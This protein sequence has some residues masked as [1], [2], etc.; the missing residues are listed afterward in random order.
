MRLSF[1]I[2]LA[3]L[4]LILSGVAVLFMG[5]EYRNAIFGPPPIAPGEKLFKVEQ[6]DKVSQITLS[7]NKGDKVDFKIKGNQWFATEPWQD[8]ADPT[9]LRF[10]VQFTA[11]LKVEEVLPRK[12]LNLSE[13]GLD[14]DYVRVTMLNQDGNTVC[15]YQIGRPTA[16]HAPLA[17]GET[18]L[19]TIFIRFTESKLKDNIYVCS[20]ESADKLHALFQGHFARFRD[21]HPLYFSPKYLDRVCIQNAEGEVVISRK[22]LKSG[23][24][25]TKPLELGVDSDALSALFVN[26]AK[27][28][29]TKVEDRTNVTLPVGEDDAAQTRELSIHFADAADDTILRIYPPTNEGE[30]TV[31]ATVS[32]RPDTVFYL[33]ES[34][35]L[36]QLQMSVNDL[37]SK[38]M[39]R[40]NGP[41]LKMIILRPEGRP[42]I[43]LERTQK[44]TWRILRQDGWKQANQD[45]I[46]NLMT[47]V[48]RDHVQKFVTD[49]ATELTPYGLDRPFLEI[50]FISFNNEGMRIAFGKDSEN[51]NIFARVAGRPNVWQ[52]S[53]ETLHK[54]PQSSWE[55]RMPHVWHLPKVDISQIKIQKANQAPIELNYNHFSANWGAKQNGVDATA[56]LNPNR[57]DRLLSNIES[58]QTEHWLG[59]VHPQAMKTLENPDIIISVSIR[60]ISDEGEDMQPVI[61]TLKIAHTPGG[62][63]HFAKIDTLPKNLQTED[64][65]SYFLLE[66]E[67]IQKLGIDLFE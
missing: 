62:F 30:T 16:W 21:H 63:I 32:D 43:M 53:Q 39:T 22:D 10:L 56:S 64:E 36:S 28:S 59:P 45:A 14:E 41:Q 46:I 55:W 58:L 60:R 42:P 44:T 4:A 13:F 49:A 20:E 19:P 3:F 48:T 7:N 24:S 2:F 57:A 11:R 9:Y 52:I 1:T 61:K 34:S 26:L 25:I 17:D 31:L 38:T 40:L 29:A 12:G 67:I 54:I 15:D 50:A 6:L 23:W 27:L 33:S 8:R 37:R 18:T 35:S 51:S 47:A 65:S 5:S 66:P